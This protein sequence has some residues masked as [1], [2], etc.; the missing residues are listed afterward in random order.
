MAIKNSISLDTEATLNYATSASKNLTKFSTDL[1]QSMKLKDI[2]EVEGILR[3]LLD[4][5]GQVD[6]STLLDYKPSLWRR[7]THADVFSQFLASYDSVS[8]VIDKV[9]GKL[10]ECNFQLKKDIE[11]CNKFLSQNMDYINELDNYIMA[12]RIKLQEEHKLLESEAK[13]VDQS[14]R[15]QVYNYEAHKSEVDRFERK[16]Y[17]LILMREI[18][19][20][21]VPQIMLIRDGDSILIEKIQSSIN[22]AIPMWESQLV[23]AIQ[24]LRQKGVIVIQKSVADATN[25]LI[26]KNGQLLKSGSIEVAKELERGIIDVEVLKKNSETL[27]STFEAIATIRD[28]GRTKR[29]QATQ[30]LAALQTKLNEQL[31]QA[32]KGVGSN[33]LLEG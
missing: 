21:N 26:V 24:L 32:G 13:E 8:D 33:A 31:I 17:D 11:V 9:K 2:P 27:I 16:L 30:E 6:A 4:G 23:I 20:Q 18:A 28:E 15:L 29:I 19:V 22:S 14:D 7:I 1:L 3:E 10:E 12:G 25:A 5:L